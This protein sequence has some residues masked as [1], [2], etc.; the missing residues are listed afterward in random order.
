VAPQAD[1][2]SGYEETS[3]AAAVGLEKTE[4]AHADRYYCL[5]ESKRPL[6]YQLSFELPYPLPSWQV[7]TGA[8]TLLQQTRFLAD[9]NTQSKEK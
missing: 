2:G 9:E 8:G 1:S 4:S 6:D 7:M 3:Q 5:V